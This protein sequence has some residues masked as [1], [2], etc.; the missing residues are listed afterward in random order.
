MSEEPSTKAITCYGLSGI[1][2]EFD[3]FDLGHGVTLSK[4]YLH[5]MAHPM[6]AFAPAPSGKH[7]PAPWQA[8]KTRPRA[9][10]VDLLAQLSVPRHPDNP[11]AQYDWVGWIVLLLRFSLDSTV[12]L[13]VSADGSFEEVAD[14]NIVARLSEPIPELFEGATVGEDE[15][16]WV[17]DNWYSSLSLSDNPALTFAVRALYNSHRATEELGVVS[18]WG[19]LER[20][21]SANAAELKYRVCTNIAAFLESAGNERYLMFKHLIKLYDDRSAAAHGSPM[22]SKTA[23]MDSFHIASRAILRMIELN[24]VPTKEDLESE[25][26]SPSLPEPS[27]S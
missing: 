22:K 12:T 1:E 9:A 25:L 16:K 7:H 14:G 27:F 19:A 8:L 3:F 10:S 21:F 23:Y 4:T 17:R 13:T 2:L 11:K 24:R 26:L 18:V 15:A 5:V 20:L 6:I